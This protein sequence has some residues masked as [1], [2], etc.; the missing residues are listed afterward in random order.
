[1][2]DS[3]NHNQVRKYLS[4]FA[5][6][7]LDVEQSLKVLEQLAMDPATT[8]RVIHQ[9]QLRKA[10]ARCLA[11]PAHCPEALRAKLAATITQA[12]PG[13]AP[14]VGSTA[15]A[16]GITGR[17]SILTRP[18]GLWAPLATAAILLIGTMVLLLEFGRGGAAVGPAVGR[19]G[20]A[21]VPAGTSL[22][23]P[24]RVAAFSSRHVRCANSLAELFRKDEFPQ[25][26]QA[27]PAAVNRHIGNTPNHPLDLSRIG[28]RYD[29]AGVCTLPGQGSVHILYRATPESGH[30]DRLSLWIR[31]ADEHAPRVE[32]GRVYVVADT[33]QPH[34]M[35]LWRDGDLLYYLM[36]DAGERVQAA[37][38]ALQDYSS[39]GGCH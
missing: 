34:P 18:L 3:L 21:L 30:R 13:P 33:S 14:A 35:L 24:E 22:L 38:A 37:A 32:P 31:A 7:E 26:V 25:D 20:Y 19:G 27:L 11:E 2:S 17:R 29:V 6:G 8:H 4:A 1:M 10:V 16:R 12:T 28:Y 36:G 23:P 39:A 5:D 9:Q 15:D